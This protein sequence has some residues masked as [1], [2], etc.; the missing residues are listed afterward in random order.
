MMPSFEVGD[1][2]R[3]RTSS[4]VSAGTFG[5]VYLKLVTIADMYFVRFDG[6]GRPTL[7]HA[8]DL[9]LVTDASADEDA[10]EAKPKPPQ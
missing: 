8:D 3:A 7:M 2:V 5:R 4:S 1:R 6:Q 9:E 10:S